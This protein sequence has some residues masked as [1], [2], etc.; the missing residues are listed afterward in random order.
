MYDEFEKYGELCF[1]MKLSLSLTTRTIE[2]KLSSF[3]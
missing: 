3:L 1:P 2:T